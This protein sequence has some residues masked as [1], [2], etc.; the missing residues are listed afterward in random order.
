MISQSISNPLSAETCDLSDNNC[1]GNID[2]GVTT[3][4][5][6]DGDEDGFG[7]ISSS[8][9]ACT[10]P[11]G[12]V[13]DT[14]DCDD[15]NASIYP[16]AVE[17]CDELD[18]DC[19]ESIDEDTST[20]FADADGDGVGVS[21][22]TIIACEL[23]EG[24]AE[25]NGDCDD[26]NPLRSPTLEEVCDDLD[27][28]CDGTI[29]NDLQ[30]EFYIDLDND[31]IGSER[32][33]VP[34]WDVSFYVF[35]E[36]LSSMPDFASHTPVEVTTTSDVDFHNPHFTAMGYT[37]NFGAVFEGKLY[38]EGGSYPLGISSDDG[39][40][41]YVNGEL[42]VDNGGTHGNR[43]RGATIDLEE[44]Y[45]DIK[46]EY[47]D[48]V[49]TAVMV[50]GLLNENNL[51]DPMS[52]D[53][54]FRYE[55][56]EGI[57][58]ACTLPEGYAEVNGDCDDYNELKNPTLTEVCDDLDNDCD[59]TIDNDLQTEFYID[60]D[61]DGVGSERTLV[62]G[63]DVSFYV[64]DEELSSMPDFA[65]HTPVEVTTTSDVDFHNPH[66]TAMGYTDNF[67]AVFEGQLYV[68]GGSYP[69]GISSDD[70]SKLY[71]NGELLVIIMELTEIEHVVQL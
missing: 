28:D 57:T 3:T 32:T 51:V 39:S 70:G 48:S 55:S 16:N 2:E 1:D 19:D 22:N 31:G 34:G 6:I 13:E 56:G 5:F 63:W 71:V 65:S 15:D 49:H 36:E 58:S 54:L 42:L 45:H 64:F 33:L 29:D 59:G 17:L 9:E 23:P 46:I 12:Y 11:V 41:L 4:Y 25:V 52:E 40:K 69:L 30:T 37:D 26:N 35:D 43:A 38:V 24:Y 47:F 60:L 62:P 20:Y 68:E 7:D 21:E 61:N 18:N 27:N 10:L 44:G 66:F 67:G 53:V 50:F 14:T 8:V